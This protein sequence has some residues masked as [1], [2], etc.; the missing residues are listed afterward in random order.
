MSF[1]PGVRS[2]TVIRELL[3]R[4]FVDTA[5]SVVRAITRTSNSGIIEQRLQELVA[6]AKLLAD[7]GKPLARDNAILRALLADMDD[8]VG[9]NLDRMRLAAGGLQ[10]DAFSVADLANRQ[11]MLEGFD[12]AT[13]SLI[14]AQW[15]R[16]DPQVMKELV[17]FVDKSA[18]E[19]QLA[20]YGDE[21]TAKIRDIAIRGPLEGWGPNRVANAIVNSVQGKAGGAGFPQAQAEN[22]MRTL[23]GQS[24]RTAQTIN[25]VANA[26][27]LESQIR[28]SALEPSRTCLSCVALHGET[29]P[30]DQRIDDHHRGL[31]T[32][33]PVIRGRPRTIESGQ[34]WWDK[35]TPAQQLAQAKPANFAALQSG[36]VTLPDYVQPYDDP[37]F[38][39]MIRESSLSGILG[40]GAQEF[41]S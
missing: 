17:D 36:A 37:V 29:F 31:C 11:L 15:N 5:G 12:E 16:V 19:Q 30:I 21:V 23:Q 9:A 1:D 28:I 41:Y 18:W 8:T 34:E 3:D 26:D 13:R 33:I 22:L 35:R 24:F 2:A 14:S 6:E 20:K 4:G 25:R 7:A 39:N 40:S 32:S 38:G 27:I 10:G